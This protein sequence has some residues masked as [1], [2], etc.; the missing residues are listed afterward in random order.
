MDLV[1]DSF[2]DTENVAPGNNE[3]NRHVGFGDSSFGDVPVTRVNRRS[4]LE[5]VDREPVVLPFAGFLLLLF[6]NEGD[7]VLFFEIFEG[8]D[9]LIGQYEGTTAEIDLIL[10]Q[11]YAAF[12]VE[13]HRLQLSDVNALRD[14]MIDVERSGTGRLY[15]IFQGKF[16]VPFEAFDFQPAAIQFR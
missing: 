6:L 7:A 14:G 16:L 1:P 9:F 10:C 15:E 13:D 5:S 3:S 11:M 8:F 2:G 4:T 12:R